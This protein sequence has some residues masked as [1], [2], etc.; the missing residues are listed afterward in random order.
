MILDTI[1]LPYKAE[2]Q[3]GKTSTTHKVHLQIIIH[4]F[5]VGKKSPKI[6]N[7]K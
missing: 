4:P 7:S 3:R 2:P 1:S 6:R 5:S